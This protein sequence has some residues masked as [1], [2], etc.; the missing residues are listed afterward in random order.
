[1]YI[2]HYVL[3]ILFKSYVINRYHVKIRNISST[4]IIQ[5]S[6]VTGCI[7]NLD[8]IFSIST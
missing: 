8:V 6:N 4:G 2:H 1:M 5:L 3:D 7:I